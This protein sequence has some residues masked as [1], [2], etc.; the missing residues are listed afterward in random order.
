MVSLVRASWCTGPAKP[1][2][3]VYGSTGALLAGGGSEA[4]Y[5]WCT[6][7]SEG[8]SR[9]LVYSPRLAGGGSKAWVLVSVTSWVPIQQTEGL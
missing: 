6:G 5:S 4:L 2:F 8:C 9:L 3:L 7:S 1:R